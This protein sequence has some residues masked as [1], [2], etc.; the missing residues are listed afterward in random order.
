MAQ[1][2]ETMCPVC[3]RSR[4]LLP[5]GITGHIV[6]YIQAMNLNT[7]GVSLVL[8]AVAA[9]VYLIDKGKLT[10]GMGTCMI[11]LAVIGLFLIGSEEY[12]KQLSKGRR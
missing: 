2:K 6:I 8:I 5:P 12:L 4:A 3:S 10:E 1:I 7:A 11:I 9:S